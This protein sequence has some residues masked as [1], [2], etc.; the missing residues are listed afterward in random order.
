MGFFACGFAAVFT[1]G[2]GAGG[3]FASGFASGSFVATTGGSFGA[4]TGG[5]G[6]GFVVATTGGALGAGVLRDNVKNATQPIATASAVPITIHGGRR[7]CS[8]AG[9]RSSSG[10]RSARVTA[11]SGTARTPDAPASFSIFCRNAAR[12]AATRSASRAC[13]S[14][15]SSRSSSAIAF[16]SGSGSFSRCSPSVT[17][18]AC[19]SRHASIFCPNVSS[20]KRFSAI[21]DTYSRS[22]RTILEILLHVARGL[23]ALVLLLLQRAH[24]DLFERA[25][26]AG[27]SSRGRVTVPSTI[28]LSISKSLLPW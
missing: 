28:C 1:T 21:G 20:M 16:T 7:G 15:I 10:A 12:S 22:A 24:H 25:G 4:T 3:A 2:S 9:G 14:P 5:A 27:S 18:L 11:S 26:Y 17:P 23:V 19:A 13:V 8:D 6:S